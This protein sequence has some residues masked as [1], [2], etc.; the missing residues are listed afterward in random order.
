MRCGGLLSA[1]ALL[2]WLA[3]PPS[4]TEDKLPEPIWVRGVT[5]TPQALQIVG[6]LQDAASEGLDPQSYDGPV[7][8]ARLAALRDGSLSPGQFNSELSVAVVK[9]ASDRRF[10]RANPNP[11]PDVD[12]AAWV[13][14][15]LA[16][17]NDPSATLQQ[18]DPPFEGYRSLRAALAD[19]QRSSAQNAGQN[20]PVAEKP[21]EQ[22]R[23]IRQ[24]QLSLERW[25]WLPRG[26]PG[27]SIIVNVPEFRLRALDGSGKIQLSMKIVVGKA[28]GLHTPAFSAEMK[29][30]IFRPYWNVPAGIQQNEIIPQLEK[31][32]SYLA[33]NDFQVTDSRG[34]VVSGGAVSSAILAAL[35]GGELQIRQRPGP[36]NALGG[37]KFVLPN[38]NDIYL[39]DTPAKA[40]FA[41]AR[42]D[43]SHGCIRLERAADLA[44]WLLQDRPGWTKPKIL[45]AMSVG[46]WARQVNLSQPIPVHIVYQTAVADKDGKAHF[47]DDIY[48]LDEA[49]LRQLAAVAPGWHPRG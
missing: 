48:G 39:H 10:G 49:L 21:G 9:Y 1:G 14:Q 7:W 3:L 2:A 31:N 34:H 25:R 28:H 30:L 8:D 11:L 22:K 23:R 24:I 20:L 13:F 16:K 36:K 40:L 45:A 19:Y 44:A 38:P 47:F 27:P 5:P 46:P 15:R 6:I 4:V 41:H 18:L 12:I 29:Y 42:R 32:P 37:L 33:V 35:R 43:F 17:S 26:Q